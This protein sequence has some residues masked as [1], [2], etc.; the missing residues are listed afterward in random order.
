MGTVS[1]PQ[2]RSLWYCT[3]LILLYCG[4]FSA[5]NLI[6][7]GSHDLFLAVNDIGQMVGQVLM[8][9]FCFSGVW[10]LSRQGL[11]SRSVPAGR[12]SEC[13]VPVLL[14]LSLISESIGLGIYAYYEIILHQLAP[15]PSW[16]DVGLL[17]AYPFLLL[18]ILLLPSRPMAGVIRVRILLDGLMI[19]TTR[20]GFGNLLQL[21]NFGWS[22]FC[23][24]N[25]FHTLYI[26][27]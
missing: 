20:V 6:K 21:Q 22:V 4:A 7:P 26:V 17:G 10:Q 23:V 3:G 11:S 12:R 5:W 13:W 19:M 24:N 15:F 16:A 9:P 14:G 18:A 25:G 1:S 27:N 2:N 8:V